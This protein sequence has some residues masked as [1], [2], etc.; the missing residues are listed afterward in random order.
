M[1]KVRPGIFGRHPKRHSDHQLR[2]RMPVLLEKRD[3]VRDR[4]PGCKEIINDQQAPHGRDRPRKVV[5][6]A[7]QQTTDRSCCQLR[8]HDAPT[9]SHH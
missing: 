1:E 6:R 7:A 8:D 2:N 5:M 3:D 4:L 9:S